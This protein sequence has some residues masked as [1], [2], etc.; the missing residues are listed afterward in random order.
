M[1]FIPPLQPVIIRTLP[2]GQH[3][4]DMTIKNEYL[5]ARTNTNV[6]HIIHKKEV[7]EKE[8]ATGGNQE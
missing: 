2:T 8:T 5:V 4:T 7:K 3:I 1:I 6:I